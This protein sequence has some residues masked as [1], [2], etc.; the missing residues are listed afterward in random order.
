M[1]R[2]GQGGAGEWQPHFL[3]LGRFAAVNRFLRGFLAF[4]LI[5]DAALI[6]ASAM[7]R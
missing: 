5:A 6:F 4:V 3:N 1:I 2:E 7:L